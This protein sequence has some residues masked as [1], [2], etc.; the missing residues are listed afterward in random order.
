MKQSQTLKQSSEKTF[1]YDSAMVSIVAGQLHDVVRR[2]RRGH[3][4][5]VAYA[6]MSK[7]KKRLVERDVRE[8]LDA[9][10]ESG[11]LV[12][13]ESE[14]QVRRRVVL[15]PMRTRPIKRR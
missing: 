7:E 3:K 8:V 13:K 9:I 4:S 12:A 15:R 6:E 5:K 1:T 2:R 14:V 10:T 11:Y